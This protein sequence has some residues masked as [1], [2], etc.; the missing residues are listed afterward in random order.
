LGSDFYVSTFLLLGPLFRCD[1]SSDS[2]R[3]ETHEK[4]HHPSAALTANDRKAIS[5]KWIGPLEFVGAMAPRGIVIQV[6][7][8]SFVEFQTFREF[9]QSRD[10]WRSFD[11]SIE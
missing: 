6:T 10:L 7:T 8:S 4:I 2:N 1:C 9:F 3:N 5:F 11:Q